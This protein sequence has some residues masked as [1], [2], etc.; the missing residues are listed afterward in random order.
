V[1]ATLKLV[2]ETKFLMELRRG[3]FDIILDG[4]PV[5]S[6]EANQTTDVPVKL[7]HHAL[8]VRT[9]RYSSGARSFEVADGEVVTFRCSGAVIWPVYL[10]SLVKPDLALVL[11]RTALPA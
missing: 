10:A 6:I 11:R 3:S 7:G 8:Q 2:R 5:G 9:G 1:P 4:Q